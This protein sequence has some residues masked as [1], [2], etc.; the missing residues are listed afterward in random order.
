MIR[1]AI[2]LTLALFAG[3]SLAQ[4]PV[5]DHFSPGGA[6]TGTWNAQGLNVGLPA[7]LTGV[8]PYANGGVQSVCT[9]AT[10]CNADTLW[11]NQP[12]LTLSGTSSA[13][14]TNILDPV[15]SSQIVIPAS[16]VGSQATVTGGGPLQAQGSVGGLGMTA[17]GSGYTADIG[18]GFVGGAN[19]SGVANTVGDYIVVSGGTPVDGNTNITASIAQATGIMTVTNCGGGRDPVDRTY[20]RRT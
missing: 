5:Y 17:Q 16:Y 11:T 14:I 2:A 1:F 8:L 20:L 10:I 3:A 6:L 12:S 13:V 15:T 18:G 4:Q 7:Y 9:Q 19:G